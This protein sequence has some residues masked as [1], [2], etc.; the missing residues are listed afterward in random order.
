LISSVLDQAVENDAVLI[1]GA[2]E[3]MLFAADRDND[4]VNI[5]ANR[6]TATNAVGNF[7]AQQRALS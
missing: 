2:P 1:Y 3:P 5:A 4:L 7:S 6:S